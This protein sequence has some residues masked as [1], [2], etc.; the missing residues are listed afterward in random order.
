MLWNF[1]KPNQKLYRLPD[2]V[3]LTEGALLQPLSIAIHACKRGKITADSK[4][5][6]LGAGPIGLNILLAAKAFG[7]TKI[8]LTGSP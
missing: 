6:I 4:V 3:S 5:L 7:A 2:H 1:D 8:M